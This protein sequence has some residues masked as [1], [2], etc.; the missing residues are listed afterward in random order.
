MYKVRQ[1]IATLLLFPHLLKFISPQMELMILPR[2][3]GNHETCSS[4]LFFGN[5]LYQY[6]VT[7]MVANAP[8]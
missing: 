6:Q 2:Y 4:I 1:L 3:M 5:L 8:V 7:V